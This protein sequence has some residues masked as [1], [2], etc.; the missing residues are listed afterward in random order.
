MQEIV[1]TAGTHIV[2]VSS[3]LQAYFTSYNFSE[4]NTFCEEVY[5][6]LMLGAS[7][8][9]KA[10]IS[11]FAVTLCAEPSDAAK[12]IEISSPIG[13]VSDYGADDIPTQEIA[14][15]LC[16]YTDNDLNYNN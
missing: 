12:P 6:T 13:L 16:R 10:K 7:E 9:G 2:P 4:D 15:P 14:Y 11:S 3:V 1:L 8:A 5:F